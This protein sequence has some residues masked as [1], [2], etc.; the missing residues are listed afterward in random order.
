MLSA[1]ILLRGSITLLK[2]QGNIGFAQSAGHVKN[3]KNVVLAKNL[4]RLTILLFL[5]QSA[6]NFSILIVLKYLLMILVVWLLGLATRAI[7][8]I[9]L[10]R[11]KIPR[12]FFLPCKQK[13][14][15]PTII[16]Q[17]IPAS[18]S[19]H[20]WTISTAMEGAMKII[21]LSI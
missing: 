6:Q 19:N 1:V 8:K 7:L 16:F 12:N 11:D 9:C 10:F 5:A 4:S 2:I 18:L 14:I 3:Q 15:F 21:T 17:L 20:C 13:I